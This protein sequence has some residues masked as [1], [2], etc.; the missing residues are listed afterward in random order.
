MVTMKKLVLKCLLIVIRYVKVL[1]EFFLTSLFAFIHGKP[2]RLPPITDDILLKP[3]TVLA[4][5]IRTGKVR[6]FRFHRA[7]TT[8]LLCS[9]THIYRV[10]E[11]WASRSRRLCSR[12]RTSLVFN[13]G[14]AAFF[15][16]KKERTHRESTEC[17][18]PT[19]P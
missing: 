13:F 11:S 16:K 15:K 6:P 19:T 3:A 12:C 18:L 14:T 2:Q 8:S 10:C 4:E 7:V 1:N 9:G 17:V 5:E